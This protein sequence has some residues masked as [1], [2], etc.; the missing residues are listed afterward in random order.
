M[1]DGQFLKL[2][3]VF[4]SSTI[5]GAA[6]HNLRELAV[7]MGADGHID[8]GRT[9]LNEILA[10]PSTA[11]E[12]SA[13]AKRLMLEGGVAKLRKNGARAIEIL[14]SLPAGFAGD[15]KSFFDSTL[16]WARNFY[17][18]PVLSA[19]THYDE[20]APHAH[21]LLLPLVGG[22]M[23]GNA[24]LGGKARTYAAQAAFYEQVGRPH[25]LTRPKPPERLSAATRAKSASMVVTALQSNAGLLDR[26]EVEA[27]LLA[28]VG[29][30]PVPML[31]ALSLPVP[32]PTAS[33]GQ[34]VCP[35]RDELPVPRPT[36]SKKSFVEI[37]TKPC[38]PEKKSAI[39][40]CDR[41][42]K[43]NRYLCVSGFAQPSPVPPHEPVQTTFPDAPPE[44]PGGG[45][46]RT[47]D[48]DESA[49]SWDE[50]LGE[51]VRSAPSKKQSVRQAAQDEINRALQR[52]FH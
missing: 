49:G 42:K 3:T 32:R 4:G 39:A 38:S 45:Y 43:D 35:H 48:D 11:I 52:R 51:F 28:A 50:R 31:A 16:V 1:D 17:K 2:G 46:S 12:V 10:G 19:V 18:L 27:A 23:T 33:N 47:R 24:I 13:L 36:A 29:H 7:E 37:M 6:K 5:L 25:G 22:R 9:R 44:I 14:A 20:G 26:P 8:V 21:I 41:Q 15:K 30:D 34:T 40:V